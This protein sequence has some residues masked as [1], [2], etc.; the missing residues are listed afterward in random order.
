SMHYLVRYHYTV[1]G[2]DYEGHTATSA[3]TFENLHVGQELTVRVMPSAPTQVI[4]T[5]LGGNL[6]S[7]T[8]L[9]ILVP[10]TLVWNGVL[11]LFL[12]TVYV[13]PWRERRLLR[14]GDEARGEV[15]ERNRLNTRGGPRYSVRYQYRAPAAGLAEDEHPHR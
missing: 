10:S 15:L 12:W 7:G 14:T 2:A 8:Y 11:G 3:G 9:S 13:S 6:G 4:Q 5:S 1:N